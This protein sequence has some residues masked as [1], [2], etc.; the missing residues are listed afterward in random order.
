MRQFGKLIKDIQKLSDVDPILFDKLKRYVYD[1]LGCC[2]EVHKDLGPWL[3]E[4]MYQD[5]LD[6]TFEEHG[7]SEDN[8]IKEYYFST[9]YHGKEIKHP[10]K[11]DFF[12]NKKVY[13][14]CKAVERLAPEHR[15]QLWNYMRL[16]GV[17]IGILYN[18][19]PFKDECEKYYLD[20]DTQVLYVF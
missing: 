14:E 16:T 20:T 6:I 5:A 8:K 9:K 18:F 11:V 4:Y 15:Q 2:M 1:I 12:I 17:R 10:H 7:Y 13:I 3:N 19:A